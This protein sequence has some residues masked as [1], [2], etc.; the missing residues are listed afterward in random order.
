MR[1]TKL[2]AEIDRGSR[3]EDTLTDQEKTLYHDFRSG[4]LIKDRND[5]DEAFGWNKEM[6]IAAGSTAIRMRR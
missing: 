4:K 1:G 5:C 3:R 2:H 6:R